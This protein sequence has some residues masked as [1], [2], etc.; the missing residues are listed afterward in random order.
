MPIKIGH[1]SI[2]ENGKIAGGK[3]GD[4]TKKEVCIREWYNKHWNVY[5]E[6]DDKTIATKAANYMERFCRNDMI[7]YDQN[8]RLTMF[9]SILANDCNV[10]KASG[11][12][13]CS[14]AISAAYVFA[15][16]KLSPACTTR[17]LRIALLNTGKF[18]AYTDAAHL[19][20]DKLAK[21]GSIHLKE[22]SHVIMNLEDGSTA[23]NPYTTPTT[24][25]EFGELGIGVRWVQWELRQSG[26][27][28][29]IDGEFGS[30]TDKTVR[31]YQ[32][33]HGLEIDGRV[34]P[35]TRTSMINN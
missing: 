1:A 20:T 27:D 12:T 11:E 23:L 7:G 18:R 35:K 21:R 30:K 34:G 6:C 32:K 3:I 24:T 9:E 2:D 22:G 31:Q 26:Y 5:L 4:Q 13:D 16:L 14:A 17:S 25:I 29:K 19:T 15:G 8:Q 10:E 28:I 33:D